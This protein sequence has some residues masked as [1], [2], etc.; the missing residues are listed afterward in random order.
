MLVNPFPLAAE[1]VW[2]KGMHIR[3]LTYQTVSLTP[4]T[5]TQPR[6]D[7]NAHNSGQDA[8]QV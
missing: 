3:S 8:L 4:A 1:F 6:L 7:G 2:D 5:I